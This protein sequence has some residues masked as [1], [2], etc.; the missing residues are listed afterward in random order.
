MTT[1][2]VSSKEKSQISRGQTQDQSPS[3]VYDKTL[4]EIANVSPPNAVVPGL[5][6]RDT[7]GA[8]TSGSEP[9]REPWNAIRTSSSGSPGGKVPDNHRPVTWPTTPGSFER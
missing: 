9:L 3:S 7:I 2:F 5:D 4:P 1:Q 8:R 6:H